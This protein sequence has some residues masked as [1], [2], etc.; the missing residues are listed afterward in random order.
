[1]A[2]FPG[3]Q[4]FPDQATVLGRTIKFSMVVFITSEE[5]SFM[6]ADGL[7]ALVNRFIETD[8]DLTSLTPIPPS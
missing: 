8:R 1:V 2:D 5:Y 6:K 4:G 7:D 3:F